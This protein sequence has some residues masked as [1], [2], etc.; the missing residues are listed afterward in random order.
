MVAL[1]ASD[2]LTRPAMSVQ[3]E[4]VSV[5]LTNTCIHTRPGCDQKAL[6][7]VLFP[8]HLTSGKLTLDDVKLNKFELLFKPLVAI[9]S[10]YPSRVLFY[11]LDPPQN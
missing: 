11:L 2:R 4:V 1:L 7:Y 8:E 9:C 6:G 5:Q 3:T 10:P